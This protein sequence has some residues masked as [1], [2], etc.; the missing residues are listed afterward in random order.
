MGWGA[1]VVVV[2]VVV[3]ASLPLE[4]GIRLHYDPIFYDLAIREVSFSSTYWY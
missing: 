2:V 3:A 4:S 1:V